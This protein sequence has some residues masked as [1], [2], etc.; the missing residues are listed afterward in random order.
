MTTSKNPTKWKKIIDL[1]IVL[2]TAIG[3]FIGGNVTAK[4]SDFKIKEIINKE[5]Q[6]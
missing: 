4:N 6:M 3:S 5:I 1:I 2:L